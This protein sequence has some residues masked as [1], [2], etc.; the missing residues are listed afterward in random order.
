[1]QLGL[2]AEKQGLTITNVQ[3]LGFSLSTQKWRLKPYV[4]T[5]YMAMAT[6]K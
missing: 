2:L 5:R 4:D 3:G 1:V 6:L